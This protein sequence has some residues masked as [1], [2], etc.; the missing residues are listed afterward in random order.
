MLELFNLQIFGRNRLNFA[1]NK[2]CNFRSQVP[3]PGRKLPGSGKKLPDLGCYYFFSP[4][5]TS[6]RI[7][8]SRSLGKS[9]LTTGKN[10]GN[11]QTTV[12]N[13]RTFGKKIPR[14]F[15]PGSLKNNYR[16]ELPASV[17]GREFPSF[18]RSRHG[19]PLPKIRIAN[20]D[21]NPIPFK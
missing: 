16:R 21:P 15:L 19:R 20:S 9:S 17:I 14:N 1:I 4:W 13:Y 5:A 6:K 10:S 18:L 11:F 7:N 2:L 8:H 12:K 3:L